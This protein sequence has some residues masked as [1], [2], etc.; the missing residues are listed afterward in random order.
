[1]KKGGTFQGDTFQGYVL[2][3]LLFLLFL[4]AYIFFDTYYLIS[5]LLGRVEH[6][7]MVLAVTI[8]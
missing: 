2:P 8:F 7:N 6:S 4:A 3:F 5:I 1:M